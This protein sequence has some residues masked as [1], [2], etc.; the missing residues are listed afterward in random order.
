MAAGAT[1][2]FQYV[3]HIPN[4]TTSGTVYSNVASQTTSNDPNSENDSSATALTVSSADI[5]VTKTAPATGN[6]GG[7]IDYVITVTNSGPDPATNAVFND[8]LANSETFV[9]VVKNSGPAA[10]CFPPPAGP[11]GTVSCTIPILSNGASAQFTITVAISPS[12]PDGTVITNTATASSDAADSNSANNTSSASTTVSASADLAVTKS[13]P[14]SVVAG[15]NVTYTINV[16]NNG[17]ANALTVSLTDTIP[18]GATFV[19]FQQNSGPSFN[20]TTGATVNCSIA[21]LTVGSSA[22]F[23]LTVNVGAGTPP[24]TLSNTATATSSTPDGNPG[25]NSSTASTTVTTSAD[26]SVTKTTPPTPVAVGFD[27]DYTISVANN[28]P[29]DAT[30]VSLTDVIPANMTFASLNQTTGPAFNC[31]TP[32]ANSTGTITCTIGTFGN[33]ATASFHLVLHNGATAGTTVTNTATISAT[34]SDPNPAN[35]SSSASVLV[36]AAIPALSASMLLLLAM[37]LGIAAW[38]AL[39]RG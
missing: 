31:T 2:T 4:G 23:T 38:V 35:N 7:T 15:T 26:L 12:T 29:S 25:N 28:G 3:G 17:L 9:S 13:G 19:S 34:T 18:A 6:A 8:T 16:T 33:G 32:A 5:G 27:V 22:A 20:C 30:G 1:A 39:R 11:G 21:T 37:S 36:L 10:N 14:A 24:G